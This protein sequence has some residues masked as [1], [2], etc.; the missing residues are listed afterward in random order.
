MLKALETHVCVDVYFERRTQNYLIVMHNPFHPQTRH[1]LAEW[2]AHVHSKVGFR[3]ALILDLL[4]LL[5]LFL[6]ME[7]IVFYVASLLA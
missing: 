2:H 6:C 3:C 1:N 4:G 7:Y 5:I